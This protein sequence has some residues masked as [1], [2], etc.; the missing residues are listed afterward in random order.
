MLLCSESV[1]TMHRSTFWT[2]DS[3]YAFKCKR[4]RNI[5]LTVT[6]GGDV[7]WCEVRWGEVRLLSGWR[8]VSISWYRALLWDLRSDITSCRNVAVWIYGVSVGR[9]LWGEDR[10]AICSVIT[11]RS[12]SRKTVT[13]LYCLIW[14]SPNLE[15]QVPVF[16]SPRNR[17]PQL[18]PRTLG[19][20]YIL[21]YDSSRLLQ[22]AGLR[23]RY[24]NPP[25]I[26]ILQEHLEHHCKAFF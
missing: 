20:L 23:W 9:P 13:I 3:L 25:L 10:S 18:H 22:L 14:K 26:Y 17:E 11:Q 5:R 4:F 16:I 2:M 7:R 19:S 15:G 6:F 21:S 8:S 1:R 24:S 12:E